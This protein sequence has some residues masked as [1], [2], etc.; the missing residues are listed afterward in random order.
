MLHI[1]YP[2][3]S[4]CPSIL[5]FLH[6]LSETQDEWKTDDDIEHKASSVA[7]VHSHS[8]LSSL[9]TLYTVYS[10][11]CKQ[12]AQYPRGEVVVNS[13]WWRKCHRRS[14]ETSQRHLGGLCIQTGMQRVFYPTNYHGLRWHWDRQQEAVSHAV[15]SW[16]AAHY[17]ASPTSPWHAEPWHWLCQD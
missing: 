6:N 10:C 13:P 12:V 17:T 4:Q 11:Q 9:H 5:N 2:A 8:L 1:H 15:S 14:W 16:T 7:L 3:K